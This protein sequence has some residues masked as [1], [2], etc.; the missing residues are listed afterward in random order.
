MIKLIVGQRCAVH[1]GTAGL[2][3]VRITHRRS[4]HPAH[5]WIRSDR[6]RRE[7]PN[8]YI[9]KILRARVYDVA[10]ETPLELAPRLSRRRGS[11]V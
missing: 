9:E 6:T 1:P 10:V 7:M 4:A 11:D 2:G 8:T 3:R 5:P